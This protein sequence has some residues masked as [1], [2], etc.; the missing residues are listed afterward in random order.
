M[1]TNISPAMRGIIL[2]VTATLF[3]AAMH[4]SVR[5]VSMS[6][7]HPFE[8][9]FFR[10]FFGLIVVMPWFLR[11][12]FA[13][14]KTS[15]LGL[16]GLRALINAVSMLAFFWALTITPLSE[17]TALTFAAP[18]FATAMAVSVF[19]ERVGWSRWVAI[20][21]GFA[22]TLVVLRP[23]FGAIGLGALLTLFATA[24][25]AVVLL[26][27][28]ALGRT[29]S[30]ITITT[31]MSLLMAPIALVPALFVWQWPTPTQLAWLVFI[32]VAGNIAQILMVQAIKDTAAQVVMP[33]DFLKL[34]WI[35][36]IA[37]VAFDEIPDLFT[38]VGAV[39]IFASALFIAYRERFP[40][41]PR[42][43]GSA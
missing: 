21:M 5:A 15:R 29:D 13:P 43:V 6:G 8:I 26:I 14:L 35:S 18:I 42:P 2:A 3:F 16:H 37:F 32:G 23:G 19:G 31:Y 25:W 41:R 34:I 24:G 33:L 11:Q 28:K 1:I 12:G 20:L 39:L 17:V 9:A 4:A 22:G 40:G 27:V 36:A 10:N 38:W 7:L 30:S